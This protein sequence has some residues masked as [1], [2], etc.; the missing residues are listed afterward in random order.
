MSKW[1]GKLTRSQAIKLIDR[2]TDHDDPFWS[3]LVEEYYDEETDTMPTIFDLFAAL[4]IT[5]DEHQ[6]ATKS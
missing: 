6:K 4:G 5:K 2:A 1:K 3:D